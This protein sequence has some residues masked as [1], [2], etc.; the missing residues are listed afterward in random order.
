[1]K[2]LLLKFSLHMQSFLESTVVYG[3]MIFHNTPQNVINYINNIHKKILIL[4]V[5]FKAVDKNQT[6]SRT[7]D[8]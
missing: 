6:V 5:I 3:K 1:M 8:V 4:T 7:Y 2:I